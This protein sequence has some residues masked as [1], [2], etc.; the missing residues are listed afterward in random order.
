MGLTDRAPGDLPQEVVRIAAMD[1]AA[2]RGLWQEVHGEDAPG[3]L[4]ARLLRLALAWEMQA[5]MVGRERVADRRGWARIEAA[6]AG[7]ASTVD[8]VQD[9]PAPDAAAGTRLIRSWGGRSHEVVVHGDHV[10]WQGRRYRSLSAVA[11]AITGTRRNGPAFFGL[12][13]RERAS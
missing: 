3:G 5:G 2:L 12:R 6:R 13:D 10:A 4:S 9:A 11:R 1:L 7:G 8:A